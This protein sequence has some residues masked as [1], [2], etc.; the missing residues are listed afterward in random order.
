[1]KRRELNQ[2]NMGKAV[3]AILDKQSSVWS[4]NSLAVAKRGL[5][6]SALERVENG[7]STQQANSAG[8]AREW[9]VKG[10]R[11][12]ANLA[13]VVS[14]GVRVYAIDM[15]DHTV[16][17][18]FRRRAAA[19]YKMKDVDCLAL[20]GLLRKYVSANLTP[21][22]DYNIDGNLLGK[23]DGA[24]AAFKAMQNAPAMAGVKV[25]LATKEVK[26]GLQDMLKVLRWWDS[27]IGTLRLAQPDL[28]GTYRWSRRTHKAGVRHISVRGVVRAE[29]TETLLFKVKVTVVES[30]HKGKSGKSGRF[31]V[32]SL[33]PGVYT[34]VFEL[35]GY[36]TVRVENVGVEAG[37]I[38]EVNVR[39]RAI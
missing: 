23:L 12:L 38:R 15:G 21:L 20:C 22:A 9:K 35:K 17:A 31:A 34:L 37:K 18:E 24:I 3:A 26:A 32:H 8:G 13:D 39:M 28:Y 16:A 1:M 14:S 33:E 11:H 19:I 27:F 6:G 29:G 10:K 30:P 4:A 7:A 25:E 36:E 2:Y 5:L